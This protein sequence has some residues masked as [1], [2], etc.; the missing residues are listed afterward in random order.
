[1]ITAP[2]VIANSGAVATLSGSSSLE[3]LG[4][5]SEFGGSQSLTFAGDGSGTL[6]L[7]GTDSYTG[8]T[9]VNNGTLVAVSANALP[10]GMAP[11][12]RRRRQVRVR[13][14]FHRVADICCG[15]R[16]AGTG[17]AGAF[18]GGDNRTSRLRSIPH[19]NSSSLFGTM[20]ELAI[21]CVS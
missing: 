4:D 6:I 8:G 17:H 18:G 11:D 16:R 19:C 15:G 1:M 13:S 2:L 20:D 3:I 10:A 21:I 9:I 7:S 12:G 5:I 14:L